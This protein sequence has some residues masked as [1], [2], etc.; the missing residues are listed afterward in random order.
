MRMSPPNR[1]LMATILK[2]PGHFLSFVFGLLS[3]LMVGILWFPNITAIVSLYIS[4]A[5]LPI[6]LGLLIWNIVWMIKNPTSKE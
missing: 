5:F 3:I 2:T 6:W 4:V 1:F